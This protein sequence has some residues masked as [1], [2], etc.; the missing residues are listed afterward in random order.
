MPGKH[1]FLAPSSAERWYHCQKSAWLCD[2]F[3]DLGSVFAAEGTEAHSLCEYLLGLALGRQGL[4]DPRPGMRYYTEEMEDCCQGYVAFVLETIEKLK[5]KESA[6][7]REAGLP[8]VYVEQS[9]DLRR[10]IPESMGTSDCI[11]IG[12][13]EV[14]VID[15]KY[16]MHRVPATSL[17][18]RIYALGA[19]ELFSSLYDF[20]SVRMV[21]YQPRIGNVDETSMAMD[22]LY[23]WA[24]DELSVR[25]GYAFRGEGEY[26][27][28]EWCRNCR[29]RRQ[30]RYLAED[31]LALARFEF[32]D[33]PLLTDEE[34]PE[35]LKQAELLE[36]WIDGV[37]K[38]ALSTLL[39]GRKIPGWKAVAGRASRRF[40]DDACVAA[41]VTAAGMDPYEKKMLGVTALEKLLGRKDFRNLLGDLV[42]RQDGKPVLVPDTDKRPE[43]VPANVEFSMNDDD[44]ESADE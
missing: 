17:Q 39:S 5:Q 13:D 31:Q 27:V 16:G 32:K 30:C 23:A 18:L 28:G 37:R 6:D 44:C 34:I 8:C 35:I 38:Y 19:C 1:A 3:P 4:V 22:D 41:R 33:P 10:Y 25:A 15:F 40:T 36:A 9:V 7:G 20:S 2:Q 24:R 26:A 11:V 29:A 43:L 21:V 14:V 12:R 42:V